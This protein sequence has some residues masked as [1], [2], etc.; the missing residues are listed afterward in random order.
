MGGSLRDADSSKKFFL[1]L[2]R[3]SG[4]QCNV[5]IALRARKS[6]FSFR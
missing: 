5:G 1:P 4:N 6:N 3:G 2:A